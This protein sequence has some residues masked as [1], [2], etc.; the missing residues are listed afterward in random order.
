MISCELAECEIH[1]VRSDAI[2]PDWS[3][4]DLEAQLRSL[5]P[6][7]SSSRFLKMWK[8]HIVDDVQ[9]AKSLNFDFPSILQL[10]AW[11]ML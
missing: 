8:I 1:A 2:C 11:K 4:T 5:L 3:L 7:Q 9:L 6:R 10:N